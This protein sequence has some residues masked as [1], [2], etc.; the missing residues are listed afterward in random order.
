MSEVSEKLKKCTIND[1]LMNY[2]GFD[3]LITQIFAIFEHQNFCKR[4]R[5]LSNV[6]YLIFQDLIQIY[7]VFYVLVTEIL[8][9]FS[10]LTYD[11]ANKCFVVYQNFVNLTSIMKTK[12]E[13]IMREFDFN[14]KLPQYY[15]PDS[16]LV[17]TLRVCVEEKQKN[18]SGL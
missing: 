14:I 3:A 5:L 11:Q 16:V 17:E 12:A 1:I 15:T 10:D 8:E 6:I 9:R 2:E 13:F 7:K 4:T 18:P